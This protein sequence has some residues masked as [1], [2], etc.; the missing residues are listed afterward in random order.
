MKNHSVF[1]YFIFSLII[2]SF[3]FFAPRAKASQSMDDLPREIISNLHLITTK[4]PGQKEKTNAIND[5]NSYGDIL[6][7]TPEV[8]ISLNDSLKAFFSFK[9]PLIKN[10]YEKRNSAIYRA[11][12]GINIAF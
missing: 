7:S 9:S 1:K 8:H 6:S 4:E 2:I 3:V 11:V 5:E 10:L 12:F